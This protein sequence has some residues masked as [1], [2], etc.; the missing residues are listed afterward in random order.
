MT[1]STIRVRASTLRG[2]RL[3]EF[4]DIDETRERLSLKLA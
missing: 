1:G 4:A 2:F 3:A